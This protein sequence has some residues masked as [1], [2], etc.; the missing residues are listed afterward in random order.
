MVARFERF[1]H[2]IQSGYG[3]LIHDSNQTVARRHTELMKS[4][5]QRGTLWTEINHVIETPMFVDSQLTSMVQLADLCAYAIRRYIENGETQ[6]FDLVFRRADRIAETSVG[7]RHFTS[8][9]CVCKIC[10]SHIAPA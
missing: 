7:V 8:S 5:L 4:F 6:L 2:N 3:L 9:G 10:A 1:L